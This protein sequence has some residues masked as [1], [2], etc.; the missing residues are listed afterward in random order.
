MLTKVVAW[1]VIF[2]F[3]ITNIS[4]GYESKSSLRAIRKIE[5]SSRAEGKLRWYE[6]DELIAKPKWLPTAC[7]ST[8]LSNLIH[9]D[10]P[11]RWIN[12]SKRF[13]LWDRYEAKLRHFDEVYPKRSIE[14]VI[15][16]ELFQDIT[17]LD[18]LTWAVRSKTVR[19]GR[20]RNV[21]DLG[22][23]GLGYVSALEAFLSNDAKII[24]VD[25][26]GETID[27]TRKK[28]TY[29]AKFPERFSVQETDWRYLERSNEI[30]KVGENGGF[31]LITMFY[32]Y[33]LGNRKGELR[34][35]VHVKKLFSH[36]RHLLSARGIFLMALHIDSIREYNPYLI[37]ALKN[38]S[39]TTSEM[40][41][42]KGG[43][44]AFI[45]RTTPVL[46]VVAGADD[47]DRLERIF[48]K[49]AKSAKARR[50][51]RPR[52]GWESGGIDE[53]Q[54][55]EAI[56]QILEEHSHLAESAEKLLLYLE[57]NH[58]GILEVIPQK[59][60][61]GYVGNVLVGL[62]GGKGANLLRLQGLASRYGF[63][64]PK[65]EI[66]DTV[67]FDIYRQHKRLQEAEVI[68][69]RQDEI[70]RAFVGAYRRA[71]TRDQKEKA[72]RKLESGKLAFLLTAFGVERLEEIFLY[73]DPYD[74]DFKYSTHNIQEF[75]ED[76]LWGE[77]G[78]RREKAL[79]SKHIRDIIKEKTKGFRRKVKVRSS[80][81]AEDSFMKSLA[82][83]YKSLTVPNKNRVAG[84]V[85]DVYQDF[86]IMRESIEDKVAVILQD[87]IEADSGGIAF[88][89]LL[90]MTT[91]EA[92]I[93]S[94]ET[95]VKGGSSVVIDMEGDEIDTIT[96]G[97]QK[98]PK[99]IIL[100]GKQVSPYHETDVWLKRSHIV[101]TKN[102]GKKKSPLTES[103]IK[104][105]I[106]VVRALER[107]LGYPVD[108]EF[109]F[110]RNKLYVIQ[111]RPVT[112]RDKG[113]ADALPRFAKE[114]VIAKVPVAINPIDFTGRIAIIEHLSDEQKARRLKSLQ[115]RFGK[116]LILITYMPENTVR[117]PGLVKV[118]I[119]PYQ[120]NRIT[121]QD[122]ALRE[123]GDTTYLGCPGLLPILEDKV[124]LD[125]I[126]KSWKGWL[127]GKIHA[128]VKLSK[129][130]IR[131]ISNGLRAIIVKADA[132]PLK[133]PPEGSVVLP[134]VGS[135]TQRTRKAAKNT[136][137]SSKLL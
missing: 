8:M 124:D 15:L 92:V 131:V 103:Q 114:D 134:S 136:R 50:R 129:G 91:I 22:C 33:I 7:R 12:L 42:L 51:S 123:E 10:F 115:K 127:D 122:I 5:T 70:A 126:G 66:L 128:E 40:L 41:G 58:P 23:G 65:F 89:S 17:T 18:F 6:K 29:C 84:G 62:Y 14:D 120:A 46:T 74:S 9:I 4:Y 110:R 117:E 67:I 60:K 1:L 104:E 137:A 69:E 97:F 63:K 100:E 45:F 27:T 93:G 49:A 121:H 88:S 125:I 36:I 83:R 112:G 86:F 132:K 39:L 87:Y 72:L 96:Y 135:T 102:S 64:V 13:K 37:T 118:M 57:E 107:E 54:R 44:L 116:N 77:I 26:I 28:V 73:N 25:I 19:R 48:I 109:V 71:K 130:P 38:S 32:P 21:L 98:S 59:E 94:P 30:K 31:D 2:T 56:R 35:E 80:G 76:I 106:R 81:V 133:D 68:E 113:L 16:Q 105:V 85:L 52:L 99:K 61:L 20:I 47:I 53:G 75:V 55:Q 78:K 90:G 11:R 24:G 34:N 43:P 3:S 101:K 79:L 111:V 95:A 119:D 108:I 82:G